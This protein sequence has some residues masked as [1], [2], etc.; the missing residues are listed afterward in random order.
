MIDPPT[1]ADVFPNNNLP[2]QLGSFVGRDQ[3]IAMTERLLARTR[4]LTLTGSGGLKMRLA[5]EMGS[6]VRGQ[7]RGGVWWVE[8][9][10]LSDSTLVSQA[11]AAALGIPE[12]PRQPLIE[13]LGQHLRSASVLLVLDNCE[14]L[15]S[16]CAGLAGILVRACPGLR[17]RGDQP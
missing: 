7:F 12:Q 13:T 15:L 17:N 3:E 9:A 14:H 1:G 10:P 5:L 4:L 2:R 11:D 8:L 6:R 16:D